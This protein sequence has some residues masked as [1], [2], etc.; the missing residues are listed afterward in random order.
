L[1]DE[2]IPTPLTGYIFF[3]A[4]SFLFKQKIDF[5]DQVNHLLGVLFGRCLFAE[6]SLNIRV[7]TV[8]THRANLM[9]KL[10]LHNMSEMVRYA[11][12]NQIIEP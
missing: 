2:F 11:V 3:H 1:R 4:R 8:E 7:K 10:D 9:R 5:L 12:R 6:E